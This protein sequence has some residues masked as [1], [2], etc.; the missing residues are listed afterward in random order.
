MRPPANPPAP[1]R[2]TAANVLRVFFALWPDAAARETLARLARGVAA[3]AAGRAPA[4][5]NLHLTLAFVGDVAP[6]RIAA[7]RTIGAAVAANVPPITL[8]LDRVGTFRGTGIVWLGASRVPAALERLAA[9]LAA[10]LATDGFPID[11]RAFRPHVTL[12]RRCRR[13]GE[14]AL[15]ARV[16]WAAMRLVLNESNLRSGAPSYRLISSWPLGALTATDP[17]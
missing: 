4:P 1:E 11:A 12:A 10:A 7:L 2:A 13:P 15:A 17:E 9:D 14:V 3:Q 5:A 6:E 8:V 16:A